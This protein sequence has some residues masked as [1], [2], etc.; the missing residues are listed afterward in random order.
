MTPS[1]PPP[2]F[3][4]KADGEARVTASSTDAFR[5][6]SNGLSP[7]FKVDTT[8]TRVG[9]GVESPQF[10]IDAVTTGT[11]TAGLQIKTASWGALQVTA[12]GS[13][14]GT[15]TVNTGGR[16]VPLAFQVGGSNTEVLKFSAAGGIGFYGATAV[17]KPT[18]VAV[19]AAGIHA[20]LVSLG[21]IGA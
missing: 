4:V 15:V 10:T 12:S 21:L 6:Q 8:N 11:Q 7:T 3:R 16:A 5:V 9:I 1:P 13:S 19:T 18:G 2:R 17:A 14:P 20:A